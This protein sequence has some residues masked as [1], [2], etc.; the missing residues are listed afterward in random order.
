MTARLAD[1]RGECQ[2]KLSQVQ[3][4]SAAVMAVGQYAMF[5]PFSMHRVADPQWPKVQIL[6]LLRG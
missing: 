1:R 3:P 6:A 4:C 2:K 5:Q